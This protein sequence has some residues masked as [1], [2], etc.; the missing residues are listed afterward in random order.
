MKEVREMNHRVFFN[1]CEAEAF[2]DQ[3]ME[4]GCVVEVW[5]GRDAFGQR[6]FEVKWVVMSE[7]G[8]VVV[9]G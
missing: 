7:N 9:K 5:S 4:Q 3:L 2:A 1:R 6:Q 8:S